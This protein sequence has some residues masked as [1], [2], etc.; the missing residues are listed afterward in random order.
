MPDLEEQWGAAQDK[1]GGSGKFL[2]KY[3]AFTMLVI[4][5]WLLDRPTESNI[6][7]LDLATNQE[8]L[9]PD[10]RIIDDQVEWLDN[11]TILY[12]LA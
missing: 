12:G 9:L 7:V 3:A 5:Q 6:A 8:T 1:P 11:S 10:T 2:R 4:A